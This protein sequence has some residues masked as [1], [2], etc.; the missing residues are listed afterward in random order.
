MSNTITCNCAMPFH[1]NFFPQTL[2]EEIQMNL[3]MI[4]LTEIGSA[5][6]MRDFGLDMSFIDERMDVAVSMLVGEIYDRVQQHEPRV[7]IVNL[8]FERDEMKGRLLPIL[9]VRIRE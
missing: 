4:L 9:E 2:P 1:L 7:E 3:F 5:P 6:L 8:T